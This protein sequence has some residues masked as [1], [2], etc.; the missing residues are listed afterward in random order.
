ML[1]ITSAEIKIRYEAAFAS[2]TEDQRWAV[3]MLEAIEFER[4]D[5]DHLFEDIDDAWEHAQDKVFAIE[6][7]NQSQHA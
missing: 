3:A 4:R 6:A 2:L 7:E 1:E 5:I